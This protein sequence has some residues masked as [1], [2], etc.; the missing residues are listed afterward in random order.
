MEITKVV[1]LS[2]SGLMLIFVGAMRLSN[3]IKTYLKNSGIT[4]DKD[5]DL[6]NE[7]RGVSAV[8]LF[9]GIL[10]VLGIFIHSFTFT[11]FVVATL[12]FLGFA[13]GRFTGIAVDG[14]PNKQIV[15]GIWFELVLGGIN[16]FCL[17]NFFI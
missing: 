3:P 17:L 1:I 5:V 7:M 9:G 10:A 4:L 11:S 6:L 2:L 14:Q 13:I 12:I 16:L 15:Q 8:M